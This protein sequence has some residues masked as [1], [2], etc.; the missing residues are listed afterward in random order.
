MSTS[1]RI[2]FST[3]A[4]ASDPMLAAW[5]RFRESVAHD[6]GAGVP[7]T[8]AASNAPPSPVGVWR[9][10][11]SNNR[12]LARS[13]EGYPTFDEARA[14]AV[15]IREHVNELD[16]VLVTGVRPDSHGWYFALDD[17]T[18]LTCG[19]WYGA[20]GVGLEAAL[21]TLDALRCGVVGDVPHEIS[22]SRRVPR[23]R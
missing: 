5:R 2:V 14:H 3:F 7:A 17:A 6:V 16:I 20:P 4:S 23:L 13:A 12:E 22:P 10:L 21:A 19:R 18:V 8:G 15:R 11:A 9:V 1:P